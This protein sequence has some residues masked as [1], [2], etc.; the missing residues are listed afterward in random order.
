VFSAD[1]GS[2]GIFVLERFAVGSHFGFDIEALVRTTDTNVQA[3]S[4][5]VEDEG[6]TDFAS[7]FRTRSRKP[8]SAATW[9]TGSKTIAPTS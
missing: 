3:G 2:E 8:G 9:R 1:Y 4:K 6:C 5:L 7:D